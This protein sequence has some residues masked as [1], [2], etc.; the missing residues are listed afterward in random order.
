MIP[1]LSKIVTKYIVWDLDGTLYQNETLGKDIKKYF[2]QRLKK[3]LPHLT[4]QKFDQL[5]IT[6]GSWASIVSHYAK[7]SEFDI[8]DDFDR[9]VCRHK[10]LSHDPKII[11]IIENKLSNY[12]HLIL[13][14]SALKE[15]Q[16]CLKKIGFNSKTFEKIYARDTTKLLKPDTNI[17]SLITAHTHTLKIRH[18]FVGDSMRHDIIPAQKSGFQAL[19]IWEINKFL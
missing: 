14:N 13:T 6:H 10:Y 8:L 18:L 17:Y 19:P 9:A 2:F 15:T 5:T 11:N 3:I 16:Q 4:N 7:H 1:W 12:H